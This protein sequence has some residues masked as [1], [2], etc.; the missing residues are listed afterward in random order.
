MTHMMTEKITSVTRMKELHD[1]HQAE[2]KTVQLGH[3]E[4]Y[5]HHRKPDPNL[6]SRDMVW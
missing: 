6:K 5:N 3:K 1:T 4:N 2:M